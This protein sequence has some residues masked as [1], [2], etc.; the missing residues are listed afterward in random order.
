M[1]HQLIQINSEYAKSDLPQHSQLKS[2]QTCLGDHMTTWLRQRGAI[3]KGRL[4]PRI[5]TL[6]M[7]KAV[8]LWVKLGLKVDKNSKH[9]NCEFLLSMTLEEHQ[10]RW[11]W[12]HKNEIKV[13][14]TQN[15][16]I[17]MHFPI[18]SINARGYIE[19][20]GVSSLLKEWICQCQSPIRWR[21]GVSQ[22]PHESYSPKCQ[23][24]SKE[25]M[26]KTVSVCLASWI[27]N[28]S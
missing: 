19:A 1:C 24:S 16:T 22:F 17:H 7:T 10:G 21:I 3:T 8:P 9:R 26:D 25:K 27:E 5:S 15:W 28:V 12:K 2:I 13:V 11:C 20:L 18:R 23:S 14:G 4:I 6:H